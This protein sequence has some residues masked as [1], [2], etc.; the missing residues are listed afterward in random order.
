[1]VGFIITVLLSVLIHIITA[2]LG[3]VRCVV[4]TYNTDVL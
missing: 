1:V 3:T 4:L 2:R